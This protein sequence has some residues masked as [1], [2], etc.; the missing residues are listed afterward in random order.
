MQ[1]ELYFTGNG[2]PT[3]EI[4]YLDNGASNHMTGDRNK[5]KEIDPSFTGK[6][7]FGDGSAVEIQG[8]GSI[9]FQ[10]KTGDQ[11]V[12]RNVYFIPK[13]RA[14]LISLGKL[15]E[16]GH[17]VVMDDD[18]IA[19]SKKNP[20]RLIMCVQRTAN[21]LYKIELNAVEPA[22]LLTSLGDQGWLWHGRLGHV[23]FNSLKQ[24]ADKEMA[25]GIPLIQ[26]P[27]QVC[28]SCLVAKQT[29]TPFPHSTHWRADEPLE[30][31][32]VDLC[33]P[34]T[35]STLSGNKYFMLLVDD[36][37]RWCTVYMLKSKD[38]AVLAFAKFKA[39]V[40]N[41]CG[42]NIKV[43]RSDRGGEFLNGVF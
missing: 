9:V 14:N 15:T 41:N 37:T 40:E 28:Q 22:C 36:C 1:P 11:W 43:L 34:I 19:I 8:I 5:F 32:H 2:E 38:E 21:R 7:R 20:P 39:Q 29:R 26:K 42:N 16:I 4:W 12:L 18:E 25:G 33:G 10:G 35:P 17:R 13:L 6:V 23:N 31:V 3:G 24:L 27:D 30:L